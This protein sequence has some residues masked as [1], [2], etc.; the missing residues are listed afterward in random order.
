MDPVSQGSLGAALAGSGAGRTRLVAALGV[1]ALSGMA[2]DLDVLIRS[3][4]DPLLFLEY[5]R[6]FSHALLFAPVGALLCALAA[7]WPMHRWLTARE[8]YVFCLLGYASHG[9][10]DACT[11]YGTQ[12][13]WPFSEAR[14]AWNRVSVVDPL[15]TLPLLG[16]LLAACLARR[17]LF[18]R[19]AVLWALAYLSVGVAQG[20]RAQEAGGALAAARGHQPE[21]LLVKPSFGNLL[22]WKLVYQADG[23]YYVDGL[24]LA[25]EVTW[26]PGERVARLDA[27]RDLPWLAAGSRQAVDLARFRR[28]SSGYLAL[29]R[30]DPQRVIDVRYSM[31]PN[32]IDALWGLQLEARAP[33]QHAEFVTERRSTP[34]D[35]A[36]LMRMLTGP[37]QPLPGQ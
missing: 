25:G 19:L 29:D 11:S 13:L 21:R 2:A 37:G 24:R 32:Q 16:L 27:A 22:V 18:A 28:F 31:V 9:L 15:F 35:R 34:A 12:L 26:F 3:D 14:I 33:Q 20:W 10:L 4:S 1:G 8:I 6:Q 30:N 17:S 23:H 7:Y 36:A 5:H